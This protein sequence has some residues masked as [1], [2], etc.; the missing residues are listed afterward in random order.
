MTSSAFKAYETTED[1]QRQNKMV[2]A[3]ARLWNFVPED[4]G[5]FAVID[6]KCY[7]DGKLVALL[8]IKSKFCRFEDYDTYLCTC[9]D[10]D[11]GLSS[12]KKYGVP[13][14]MAVKFDNFWG[15]LNITH[16]NFPSRRSGQKNRNDPKDTLAMCYLIPMDEFKEL[17]AHV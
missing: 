17:K 12:S 16:A 15:Y 4:Q 1:R 3:I 5:K 14:I 10:I 13:F 11:Y 6:Y 7:R 8:E 9:Q 2:Q